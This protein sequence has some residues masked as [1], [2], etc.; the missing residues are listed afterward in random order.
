MLRATPD[1]GASMWVKLSLLGVAAAWTVASGGHKLRL[2]VAARW[3]R[4]AKHPVDRAETTDSGA[5][6]SKVLLLV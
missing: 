2:G 1:I 3:L 4:N 6:V 5:F